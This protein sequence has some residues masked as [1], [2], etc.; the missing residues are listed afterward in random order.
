M[1]ARAS[2]RFIPTIVK[3]CRNRTRA[4]SRLL[5]MFHVFESIAQ[6]KL[7][8]ACWSPTIIG[9]NLLLGWRDNAGQGSVIQLNTGQL[10]FFLQHRK[11]KRPFRPSIK[12]IFSFHKLRR[13]S[14]QWGPHLKSGVGGSTWKIYIYVSIEC[15]ISWSPINFFVVYLQPSSICGRLRHSSNRASH[16]GAFFVARLC[17][18]IVSYII[19]WGLKFEWM[20][21][22]A[23]ASAY[24][25]RSNATMQR[26]DLSSCTSKRIQLFLHINDDWRPEESPYKN[27]K[28][29]HF[30][31]H[32]IIV[33][34]PLQPI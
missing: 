20:V 24:P 11:Q 10:S 4:P 28:K 8:S 32:H 16:S 25:I 14:S 21:T 27:E 26:N 31:L 6:C 19:Y 29:N 3:T 30:R 13:P 5:N 1:H 15:A 17:F 34:A 18:Q 2:Y 23:V 7:C 22:S 9:Y 33:V 12:I